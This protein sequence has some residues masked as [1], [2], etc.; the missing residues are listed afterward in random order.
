[1]AIYNFKTTFS[2]CG[3]PRMFYALSQFTKISSKL[4]KN[5]I[6]FPLSQSYRVIQ[7][8]GEHILILDYFV[9]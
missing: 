4:L 6:P 9:N 8:R 5:R 3:F 7:Q 1:M 2:H